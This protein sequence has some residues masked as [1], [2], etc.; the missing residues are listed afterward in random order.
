MIDTARKT[1]RPQAERQADRNRQTDTYTQ[2]DRQIETYIE[3]ETD[4]GS[5]EKDYFEYCST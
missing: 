2:K 4:I 3:T 1:E 5:K